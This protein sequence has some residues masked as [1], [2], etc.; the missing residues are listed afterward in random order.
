METQTQLEKTF[1]SNAKLRHENF[2]FLQIPQLNLTELYLKEIFKK[3]N[4]YK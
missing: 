3:E 1:P 4:D 2:P